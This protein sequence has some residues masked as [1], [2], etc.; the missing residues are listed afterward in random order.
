M[1]AIRNIVEA[2]A[3]SQ[4]LELFLFPDV[5]RYLFKRVSGIQAV[6]AVLEIARPVRQFTLCRP[7]QERREYGARRRCNHELDKCPL[8]HGFSPIGI[9]VVLLKDVYPDSKTVAI[10]H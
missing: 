8:I 6:G 1:R 4:H 2:V 3:C 5:T 10:V 7:A 9:N